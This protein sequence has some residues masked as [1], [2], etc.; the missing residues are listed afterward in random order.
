MTGIPAN[1]TEV[2]ERISAAA[3][4]AG[5]PAGR[6]RLIAVS[7]TVDDEAIRL[8]YAAGQ[9]AFGENRVRE[10]AGK[11]ARLP[12]DCEWHLIGQLQRNKVRPAV[13]CAA[14]IHSADGVPLLRRIDRIAAEEG[15]RPRVLIEVNISGED[16]K[17]G[18]P[19]EQAAILLDAVRD[20]PSLSC[21]GL[22][23]LAPYGA[24]E[25]VLRQV[26]GGLRALRD[27]LAAAT[28]MPL[29]ELSMGM[30]GDYEIAVEEG[31]TMVRVGTAIFGSR[32]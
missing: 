13:T 10:M 27:R 11:S 6:V 1:L 29:P 17:S 7:K 22:M 28:G 3:S 14:W 30:S 26:F 15:V 8:A 23:T 5:R 20:L 32:S 31:A 18:I 19:P 2:R 25:R 21:V 4:R 9:R 24:A 16:S 12:A